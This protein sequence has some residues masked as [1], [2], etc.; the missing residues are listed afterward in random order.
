ML[1]LLSFSLLLL[2][3]ALLLLLP[4]L[5][6]FLLPPAPLLLLLSPLLLFLPLSLL[7]TFPEPA[8][9]FPGPVPDW[10]VEMEAYLKERELPW[11]EQRRWRHS[12]DKGEKPLPESRGTQQNPGNK[13]HSLQKT[14]G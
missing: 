8:P 2:L 9:L 13:V 5:P 1:L 7:L 6:L 4:S 12:N 3:G 14:R 11:K 10:V